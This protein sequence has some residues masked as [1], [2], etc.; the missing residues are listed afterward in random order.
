[1]SLTRRAL[2]SSSASTWQ[3]AARPAVCCRRAFSTTQRNS[4]TEFPTQDPL[5]QQTSAADG[6]DR[7]RWSYTPERMKAP[8]SIQQPKDPRRSVWV[9]NEDPARLERMYQKLVGPEIARTLPDELKWLAVT[10]K[11]FDNGRRGF[12]TRL[13]FFGRMILALE[14]TRSIMGKPLSSIPENDN[15]NDP[16]GRE[17]FSHP[18]LDC[19]DKLNTV[20]PHQFA[21]PAKLT[22]L[23]REVDLPGV[24]RWK[25]RMP[26]NLEGS[27]MTT[28]MTS[29]LLAIIGAVSLHHG[30]D[31]ANRVVQGRIVKHLAE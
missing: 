25:P 5:P 1:M 27:G 21:T 10:H 16:Y 18:A 7:P 13:A 29:T 11:S 19:V 31:V 22:A 15:Q 20:Q 23:A 8:F 26:D 3:A 6:Q 14:T 12:N 30:A 24:V 9:V 4:N 17:A 28:V 2:Q